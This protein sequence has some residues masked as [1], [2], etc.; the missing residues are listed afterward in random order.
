MEIKIYTLTDPKSKHIRYVG[1]TSQTLNRRLSRHVTD[2]IKKKTHK[3][4]WIFGLK[5]KNL[6][7]I[8]EVI[9]IVNEDKW[10]FWEQHYISLFKSWGFNLVNHTF[11]GEGVFGLKPWNKGLKGSVKP[12]KTSIKM[13][14]RLSPKTEFKKGQRLSPETE[15]KKNTIPWNIGLEWSDLVKEKMSR[16]KL[17]K[18]SKKRILNDSQIVEIRN[19]KNNYKNSELAI[20]FNIK[21]SLIDTVLYSKTYYK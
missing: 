1:M 5:Q 20:M 7:P 11:G 10:Q 9:D 19:L 18:K 4:C 2:L 21:K 8:I 3:D 15:F 12:N 16:A 6:S 13:G 17:G 14:Q